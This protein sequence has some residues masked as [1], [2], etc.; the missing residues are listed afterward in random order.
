MRETDLARSDDPAGSDPAQIDEPHRYIDHR[1][2]IVNGQLPL[3]YQGS[4]IYSF[5]FEA[6]WYQGSARTPNPNTFS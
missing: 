4:Q 1:P 3:R 2:A 6:M 5:Q